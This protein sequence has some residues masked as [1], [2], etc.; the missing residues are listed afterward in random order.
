MANT[1]NSMLYKSAY[2]DWNP[3]HMFKPQ[4][5]HV[6]VDEARVYE[7]EWRNFVTV[8]EKL[9][10]A[11]KW[12]LWTIFCLMNK[13]KKYKLIYY[14]TFII[15]NNDDLKSRLQRIVNEAAQIH[16]VHGMQKAHIDFADKDFM[17]NTTLVAR[18]PQGRVIATI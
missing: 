13:L 18:D 15:K 17:N 11:P 3:N 1:T 12:N 9:L 2:E 8:Y 5:H 6:T 14:E 7:S 16:I 4:N 10:N